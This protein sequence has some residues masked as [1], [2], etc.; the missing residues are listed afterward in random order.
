MDVS[1][2][3]SCGDRI[4]QDCLKSLHDNMGN[5]FPITSPPRQSESRAIIYLEPKGIFGKLEIE[6]HQSAVP[7]ALSGLVSGCIFQAKLKGVSEKL[8]SFRGGCCLILYG[9]AILCSFG[10]MNIL[11][12][13]F[14]S[15][16]NEWIGGQGMTSYIMFDLMP[17]LPFSV[18]SIP[19]QSH[20]SWAFLR[21][22]Y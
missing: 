6:P 9:I 19:F 8:R 5:A 2:V 4:R 14:S 13:V 12:I 10:S 18:F 21:R 3:E 22:A 20:F 1:R 11:L 15:L 16:C 17:L 7:S